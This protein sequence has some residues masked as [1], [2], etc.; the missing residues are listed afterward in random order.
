MW[1]A[2]V[3]ESFNRS[4]HWVAALLIQHLRV[5]QT[6][7]A[8][9]EL[10]ERASEQFGIDASAE[11]H[12]HDLFHGKGEF[13]PMKEAP[14]ARIALYAAALRTLT[15]AECWII[16]RGVSKPGLCRRYGTAHQHPHRIVMT[17]LLERID[18]FCQSSRGADD[19]AVVVAD[20]HHETQSA[21]LRDLVTYQ[22]RSTWGYLARRINRVVDT[23]HFV[24]SRTNPLVQG[25]DLIAFLTL[26]A[27]TVR[28]PHA[29]AARATASVQ[30]F[31]QPHVHH[32]HCWWP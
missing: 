27:K 13:Q 10:V 23:I 12:G 26:R 24:N 8:M 5:N 31:I 14:R 18:M 30:A 4:Q 17:H 32:D 29:R 9:R 25:A 11:L 7:G 1:F 15:D 2:Y 6:A 22:D 21:L 19:H 16:L 28:E 3:D 20:E